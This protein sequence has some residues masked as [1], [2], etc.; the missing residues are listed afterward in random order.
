MSVEQFVI[1]PRPAVRAFAIAAVLALLGALVLV[2]DSLW[3]W[4]VAAVVLAVL[5]VVAGVA[6]AGL[7]VA[8]AARQR[9]TVEL[10]DDGFRVLPLSGTGHEGRWSEVTRVTRAA[11]RLTLHSGDEKRIHLIAPSGSTADLDAL[12]RAIGRRLDADRGYT[13]FSG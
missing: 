12:G 10:D 2:A 5:L 7:A 8:A 4:G 6:L 1:R 3:A 11:G 9:V 13:N